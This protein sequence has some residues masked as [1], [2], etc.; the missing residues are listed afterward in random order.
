MA[1]DN[2]EFREIATKIRGG[3]AGYSLSTVWLK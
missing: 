3:G 2:I 1:L